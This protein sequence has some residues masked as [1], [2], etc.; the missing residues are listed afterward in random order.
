MRCQ[1]IRAFFIAKKQYKILYIKK[2]ISEAFLSIAKN[3]QIVNTLEPNKQLKFIVISI[4][5][6]AKDTLKKEKSNLNTEEYDDDS[7]FT[8]EGFSEYSI[9]DWNESIKMLTQTDKDI[10]Y[11]RCILQLEYKEIAK[12]L[13]ISQG[14]ARV[15]VYTA[16]ENLK[17][18]LGKEDS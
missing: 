16:R 5:N 17:K 9:V 11:L 13:G 15:R 2:C 6:T 8:E 4:R 14:A 12:T 10:L 3:F 18:L 1:E 7:F